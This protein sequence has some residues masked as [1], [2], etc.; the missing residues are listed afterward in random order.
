MTREGTPLGEDTQ[1][2]LVERLRA[3]LWL[4]LVGITVFAIAD[5]LV[6][7]AQLRPLTLV[8][9][10]EVTA[11]LV[12]FALLRGQ[13]ARERATVVAISFICLLSATTAASGILTADAVTT[14]ILLSV[15]TMGTATLLP[16]GVRP[17]LVTQTVAG[18][19]I[20]WNV[21]FVDGPEGVT[22]V[23]VAVLIGS[24]ASVYAAYTLERYRRD[25]RRA[26]RALIAAQAGQHQAELA[27]AARL[28]T[29]GGMAAGL[30]HEL[31]QP[32]A[33][34]VAYARGC[35]RRIE[36]GDAS[37]ASL[38]P[39]VDEI[40][41][42]A[43]RAGEI[44][45]RI[46]DFVRY[47]EQRREPVDVNELVRE[48][49]RLADLEA[50]QLG[51][52]VRLEL[53]P[54]IPQVEADGIQVEQVVLNLVRNGF[55]AMRETEGRDRVLSIRT[56]GEGGRVEV[57][58][59]DTGSGVPTGIADRLFD[60]FFTTKHDGLGLGL[61]ISRSLIEANGGRLWAASNGAGGATFRFALPARGARHAA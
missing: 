31:N 39:A 52:T 50:R 24:F 2:L 17:Q 28:S 6:H 42:Q 60:P 23:P 43:L 19:C 36:S 38:L 51:V 34:I 4:F 7:P 20:L 13:H 59:E 16:W 25:R 14:P 10:L 58:V 11:V 61:S 46:R 49:A 5:P 12:S 53:T 47:G 57:A 54:G 55:E 3:G 26:E 35:A 45:R 8:K 56:A 29:L 15:V 30:A 33:A 9:V 21:A 44:L 18:L 48:A 41:T 32:L 22:Y 1:A 27:H 40:A 37:L